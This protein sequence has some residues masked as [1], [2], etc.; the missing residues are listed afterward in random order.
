MINKN[1]NGIIK[2][3]FH[4]YIFIKVGLQWIPEHRLNME[5]KLGRELDKNE[6][7]HHINSDRTDNEIDNL[8]LFKNQKEHASFH[9]KLKQHG[10]TNPIKRQIENRWNELEIKD[11]NELNTLS[12]LKP[13]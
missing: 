9:T 7:I 11:N 3:E 6:V 10:I 12:Q 13:Y 8:M 2:K 1:E 4:R 5:E